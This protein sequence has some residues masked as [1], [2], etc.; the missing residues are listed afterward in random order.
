[1]QT[2]RSVREVWQTY[3]QD[4]LR[5]LE[6]AEPA[7]KLDPDELETVTMSSADS[8]VTDI[9]TTLIDLRENL[10]RSHHETITPSLQE[11]YSS[12]FDEAVQIKG[13]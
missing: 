12:I 1:M 4:I 5:E 3:L 11:A 7:L 10:S 2:L 6:D 13:V 9:E 8:L